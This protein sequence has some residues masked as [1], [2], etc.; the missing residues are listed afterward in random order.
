[1]IVNHNNNLPPEFYP[2]VKPEQV[3]DRFLEFFTNP[4]STIEEIRVY[5]TR[6]RMSNGKEFD[7]AKMPLADQFGENR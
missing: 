2:E 7:P 1:M 4:D 3:R 6:D 5:R